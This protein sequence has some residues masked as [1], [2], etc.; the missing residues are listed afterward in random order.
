MAPG[1]D[2]AA[3]ESVPPTKTGPIESKKKGKKWVKPRMCLD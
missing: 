2:K 3:E 1:T